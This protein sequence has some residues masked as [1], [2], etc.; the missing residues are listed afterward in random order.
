MET[1]KTLGE[2]AKAAYERDGATWEEV[3]EKVA[4]HVRAEDAARGGVLSGIRWSTIAAMPVWDSSV[5]AE[6]RHHV[7][8]QG[9]TIAALEG[10]LRVANGRLESTSGAIQYAGPI[11]D[12]PSVANR[13]WHNYEDGRATIAAKDARIAELEEELAEERKTA[14]ADE[15][16]IH[17]AARGRT[18]E[19]AHDAV[20]RLATERDEA[21]AELDKATEQRN[22]VGERLLAVGKQLWAAESALATLRQVVVS[23]ARELRHCANQL[24][25]LGRKGSPEGSVAKALAQADAALSA[26]P[27]EHPDT[28]TLRAIRER[29]GDADALAMEASGTCRE[30]FDALT[31]RERSD[32][33]TVGQR[34]GAYII[35]QRIEADGHAG[36][37]RVA[38][39]QRSEIL[40][41]LAMHPPTPA[42]DG[43][44]T[45]VLDWQPTLARA[46]AGSCSRPSVRKRWT[47]HTSTAWRRRRAPRR[48]RIPA[49]TE[50]IPHPVGS[51]SAP[52]SAR[53][54]KAP[55]M[56]G[57][58]ARKCVAGTTRSP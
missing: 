54:A 46:G 2:V 45:V 34:A 18:D 13:L 22:H 26:T 3:A 36:K 41:R 24:A 33:T 7:F 42:D 12:L 37:R 28:A 58:A 38:E 47:C 25:T 20:V 52:A 19:T 10:D 43:H 11:E 53:R 31:D 51:G 57:M 56:T 40:A 29:A 21:R 32:W 8:A 1:K 14:D 39:K 50:T 44:G 55:T 48:G 16:Q 5:R 30:V 49:S 35:G 6:V 9:R 4:A 15:E 17:K 27:P 23:L